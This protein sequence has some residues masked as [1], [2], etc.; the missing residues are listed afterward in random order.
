[1]KTIVTIFTRTSMRRYPAGCSVA[2]FTVVALDG[3]HFQCV[4]RE[5]GVSG[6]DNRVL[7][8]RFDRLPTHS[9]VWPDLMKQVL[10]RL[11]KDRNPATVVWLHYSDV[12]NLLRPEQARGPWRDTE[13][14]S[15]P[16]TAEI[17]GVQVRATIIHRR[18]GHFGTLAS[19][20]ETGPELESEVFDKVWAHVFSTT[21][22][23]PGPATDPKADDLARFLHDV[24]RVCAPLEIWAQVRS[25]ALSTRPTDERTKEFPALQDRFQALLGGRPELAGMLESVRNADDP[26]T[27]K[28]TL[29]KLREELRKL[30]SASSSSAKTS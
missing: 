23:R 2:D 11:N 30:I 5:I 9:R 28:E 29:A 22:D 18:T 17:C 6:S 24:N 13:P 4:H 12:D 25:Q 15:G 26:A 10:E 16:E 21:P 3:M 7:D 14:C 20:C 27:F 1:M 8:L 19:A